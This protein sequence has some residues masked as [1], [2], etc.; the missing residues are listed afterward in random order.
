[1]EATKQPITISAVVDVVGALATGSLHENVYLVDT[2]RANGSTGSGTEELMTKVKSG[3]E[4][5]WTVLPLECEAY[6]SIADIVIDKKVCEPQRK[7][8]P[9][10]DVAYWSGTVKKATIGTTPYN[11]KFSLGT[12]A[13]PLTTATTPFLVGAES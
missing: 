9:G 12:R 4:L 7:V 10:T 5:I 3:D 8:Y 1:M 13:E 11:I 2:N 6:V